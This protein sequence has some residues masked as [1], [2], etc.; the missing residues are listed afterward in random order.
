VQTYVA[1]TLA[2]A[3][4]FRCRACGFHV[5]L[6]ALDEVPECPNCGGDQFARASMFDTSDPE[7]PTAAGDATEWLDAVRESIDREGHYLV[8]R[9][10]SHVSVMPLTR[11]WTKIGRS[12]TA[13]IRLDDPTV[14]RRHA[15]VCRQREGV[16]VLDDRS[17]NGVF[18]NGERTEWSELQDG[19]ELLV[20]RYRLFF[21][22]R[23][24]RAADH[25]Q[26]AVSLQA[27]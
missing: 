21:V 4:S 1:G 18:L 23:A 9:D 14:S 22:D 12:L 5:A 16:R 25:E 20:G 3:G 27:D 24:G 7:P 2:G 11:E 13:D 17:L 8:F 15:L 10:G 6:R 19:D 26:P